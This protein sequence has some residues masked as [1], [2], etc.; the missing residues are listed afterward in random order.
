MILKVDL[1]TVGRGVCPREAGDRG[2]VDDGLA[3]RAAV[4]R[5]LIRGQLMPSSYRPRSHF[6]EPVSSHLHPN[7]CNAVG[8]RQEEVLET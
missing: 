4:S 2:P 3:D 5:E 6:M 1:S 7:T 8:T